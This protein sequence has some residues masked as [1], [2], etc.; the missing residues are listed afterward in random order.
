[1]GT[2]DWTEA[3]AIGLPAL[4]DQHKQLF[5]IFDDLIK[6][7]ERS[8]GE[9]ALKEIFT[10]LKEYTKYHFTDEENYMKGIGYPDSDSHAAEHALLM[11]RVDTLWRL[12]E[13]GENVSPKGV[14]LFI[15]DWIVGHIINSDTKIGH[16]AASLTLTDTTT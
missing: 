11:V 3:L 16:Y 4:D 8:E 12:L 1:M 13:G 7:I 15:S 14:S 2:L 5:T 9:D 6:A 10:R